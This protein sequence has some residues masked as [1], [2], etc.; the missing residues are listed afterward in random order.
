MQS[1][2]AHDLQDFLPALASGEPTP[3]GG[4]AAALAGALAAAL[5]AMVARLT[6]G[7]K[8]YAHVDAQMRQVV[9]QA[10]L[11]QERLLRLVA[12]DALAYQQVRKAYQLPKDSDTENVV[13][14]AAI[15]Q[16]LKGAT[17]SPL[18]TMSSCL[19]V[20]HLLQT[21]VEFG[22]ENAITDAA[23]GALLGH[24]ALRGAVLN[25]HANIGD[26][27]D[28]DYVAAAQAQVND[29]LTQSTQLASS[30]DALVANRL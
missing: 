29:A 15:Q 28:P 27:Q 2:D 6:A 25:V 26:I 8:R 11:L 4:S 5:A 17:E 3:G 16:A 22:N 14:Q 1:N 20:L 19:E 24:A 12:E 9:Q 21:V 7:R 10:D 13:R 18:E 30:I 23:V